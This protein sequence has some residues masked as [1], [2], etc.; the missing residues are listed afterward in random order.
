[1]DF[2]A[3]EDLNGLRLPWNVF[4]NTRAEANRLVVPLGALYT[5]LKEIQGLNI[6]NY[7]PIA[8]SQPNCRTILNPYSGLDLRS[9]MWMCPCCGNRNQLPNHYSTITPD[10][11]PLELQQENA[12]MEYILSRPVQQP[13]IFLF[14]VDLCQDEDNLEALKET[15]VIALSLLPPNALVGLITFG[16]MVQLHDLSSPFPKS[17]VFR[18]NKDYTLE[19]LKKL[20]GEHFIKAFSPLSNVEFQLTSII[21]NLKKDPW[22]IASAKRALRA[23]GAALSIAVNLC[24]GSYTGFG[25]RIQ[26][27]ASGPCTLSPGLIVSNELKE[28]IRSHSDIDKDS[29]KHYK[30]AIK[31]YDD[32]AVR[33]ATNGHAV[34][35]FAGCYDQVGISEMQSL[36]NKTGGVLLLTDAFTTSIFKQSYLRLFSKDEEGFLLMGFNATLD[37]KTSKELKVAGLI[38]HASAITKTG[39]N[40]ADTEIGIGGTSS[41]KMPATSPYHTYSVFFELANQVS[42]P[43]AY[44]QFITHYQ[45]ASG[46]YRVRVTT[47][48]KPLVGTGDVNIGGGFDQEAAAVVMSRIATFKAEDDD[49]ADVIRWVDRMLIKLCAKFAD[50]MR[51]DPNSFRLSPN[52]TLYPQFMFYLRRSQFLQ[53]FN[54]SPDETAFY[55]HVLTRE[56][57]T[58]SLIMIQPTLTS[59]SMDGEPTPVLLDS[60]SIQPDKILL[61]D[62]FFHILIY[63]GETVASWRNQGY[64]DDPEYA[65]FKEFLEEPKREAAELLVDRFPLPRF[66]DTEEGGSQARFLYSKLNP[67]T[68]YNNEAMGLSTGGGVVLTD[69][70]SL[71]MFME[72]L[73]KLA[74]SGNT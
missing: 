17:F 38:G 66:I 21:E 6:A 45:H 25:A 32:L 72:H 13:P 54:N 55:R 40:I 74:V 59:F 65:S 49:S 58:N 50:Y 5:P 57:T 29:A 7:D 51:D 67:S 64:Q 52:F 63:H 46:T 41:W 18:G 12:T 19:S 53:V 70:V 10:N 42:A 33:A 11:L 34:D 73:Q 62:T 30:K 23:T 28:P 36:S 20:L 69:D 37:V 56:D 9:R 35:I 68:S 39:S 48:A 47:F 44:V 4:P 31:F 2:E 15:L 8:C 24:E 26:L 22:P 61:L 60:I 1:M 3:E 16:A 71:Q 14:V 43:H 27:F